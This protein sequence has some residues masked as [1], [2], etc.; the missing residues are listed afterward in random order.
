LL[1]KAVCAWCGTLTLPRT[2]PQS[3]ALPLLLVWLDHQPVR[4]S[5]G[6]CVTM[7]MLELGVCEMTHMGHIE[8]G[9]IVLDEPV[10]LPDGA[11]VKIVLA[12][13]GA[14]ATPSSSKDILEL[15][16]ALPAGART[17]EDIDRQM[18]E[19]RMSWGGP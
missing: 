9:A 2:A 3:V 4:L 19:E 6:A 10:A 8:N 17:K 1:C 15:V 5:L 7:R 18:Q 12:V 14:G 11:A 13:Q 16:S